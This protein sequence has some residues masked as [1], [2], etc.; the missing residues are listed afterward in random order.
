MTVG[1]SEILVVG[2]IVAVFGILVSTVLIY[3]VQ[4]E[5]RLRQYD[6]KNHRS[7]LENVRK[8]FEAQIYALTDRMMA[9]DQRWRDVNHLLIP[10]QKLSPAPDK[11]ARLVHSEFLSRAGLEDPDLEQ[12]SKLVFVLTP[13]HPEYRNTYE[14]VASVCNA[15]GLKCMRGD[16]EYIHGDIFRH[17]LKLLVQCR[18]V[19]ANVDGRNPNVFYEL[20]IAQAIGKPVVML[21]SSEQDVPFDIRSTRIIFWRNAN[22]LSQRLREEMVKVFVAG[23]P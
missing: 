19:I 5:S 23:N 8:S 22:E 7:E 1:G 12:D 13:F 17:I 21:A 10:S 18:L 3:F 6:E 4:R 20:G 14:I 2:G 11:P 15:I 16:E 9:S